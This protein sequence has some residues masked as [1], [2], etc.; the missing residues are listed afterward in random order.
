MRQ[1]RAL[2][3]LDDQNTLQ[4]YTYDYED[5]EWVKGELRDL[6]ISAHPNTKLCVAYHQ[7]KLHLY[8]QTQSGEIQEATQQRPGKH[9]ELTRSVLVSGSAIGSA[10]CI[11]RSSGDEIRVFYVHQDDSS[12]HQTI[13]KN[14]EWKGKIHGTCLAAQV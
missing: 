3:C 14:G 7:S 2:F 9:W 4:D 11:L 10:I 13:S 12:I 5:G 8:F 6:N 1:G